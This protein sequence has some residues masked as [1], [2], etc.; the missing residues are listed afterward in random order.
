MRVTLVDI[1]RARVIKEDATLK[2]EGPEERRDG[3]FYINRK[4]VKVEPL[5]EFKVESFSSEI[6]Y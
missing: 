4:E 1:E 3:V 2:K 5:E 6:V